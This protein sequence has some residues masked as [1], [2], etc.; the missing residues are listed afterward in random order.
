[1]K[2]YESYLTFFIHTIYHFFTPLPNSDIKGRA[3]AHIFKSIFKNFLD[4]K[5]K[6]NRFSTIALVTYEKGRRTDRNEV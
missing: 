1:M 5:N 4:Q 2:Q 3:R 6:G